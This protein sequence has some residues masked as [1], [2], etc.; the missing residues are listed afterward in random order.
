MLTAPGA[1]LALERGSRPPCGIAC[2][3]ALV[4]HLFWQANLVVPG[5]TDRLYRLALG[6]IGVSLP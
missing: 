2:M 3:L 4:E 6:G 1:R 5:L